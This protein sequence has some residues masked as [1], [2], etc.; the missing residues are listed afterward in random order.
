M[1]K[2]CRVHTTLPV[3]DLARA[4]AFYEDTLGIPPTVEWPTGSFYDCGERTRFVLSQTAG[5]P[6]GAHTQMAFA[7]D[8]IINEVS[9]LK[10]RG[11]VFEEYDSPTMK[12][13]DGIV[14]GPTLKAAWF[15]DVDGNLLAI[16]Q[17]KEP[18]E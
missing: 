13:V 15:K 14:D 18:L 8:D 2:G 12:T 6:S 3:S 11:V 5:R 1:L 17:P 16:I 9:D 7:V 4:R 10:A